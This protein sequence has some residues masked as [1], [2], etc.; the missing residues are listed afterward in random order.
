MQ[1]NVTTIE[2]FLPNETLGG[3]EGERISLVLGQK[4]KRDREKKTDGCL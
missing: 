2:I 3:G 1:Q 4:K